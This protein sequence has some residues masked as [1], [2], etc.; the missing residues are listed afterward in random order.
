VES[1]LDLDTA[2]AQVRS[3]RDSAADR[4]DKIQNGN[5]EARRQLQ[6]EQEKLAEMESFERE[7]SELQAQLHDRRPDAPFD[8]ADWT[9]LY[10]TLD[11]KG[12]SRILSEFWATDYET[13]RSG[14]AKRVYVDD[15]AALH[16]AARDYFETLWTFDAQQGTL[17]IGG[18]PRGWCAEFIERMPESVMLLQLPTNHLTL[19]TCGDVDDLVVSISKSN[20]A[21]CN[22]SNAW[23][24]ASN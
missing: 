22:F 2:L 23:F 16:P 19:F 1:G 20:L 8:A 15:P 18:K 10:E 24:D 11:E 13:L 17:Q 3:C 6:A 7:L 12:E 14:L 5:P 4:L 21:R 9:S